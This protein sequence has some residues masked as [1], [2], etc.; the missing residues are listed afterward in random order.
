MDGVAQPVRRALA[1]A[2]LLAGVGAVASMTVL[3]FLAKRDDLRQRIEQ[4]QD[5]IG[6]LNQARTLADPEAA[7]RQQRFAAVSRRMFVSG[8]SQTIRMANVQSMVVEALSASSLKPRSVRNLPSRTRSGFTLLGVQVQI[9]A[10]LPQI[11][12]V[13]TQLASR[14]PRLLVED[15]QIGA[16][17]AATISGDGQLRLL[18]FRADVYGIE[19]PAQPAEARQ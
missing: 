12:Q 1:V 13:L 8:N 19:P 3:P 5:V 9:Q 10:S 16:T 11:Q 6:R 4:T 14:E 17:P 18:E 2:L 15:L 7:A